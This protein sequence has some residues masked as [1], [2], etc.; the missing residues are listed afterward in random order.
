M[1]ITAVPTNKP[2]PDIFKS[3]NILI[4]SYSKMIVI[5]SEGRPSNENSFC[6]YILNPGDTK[7]SQFHLCHHLGISFSWSLYPHVLHLEND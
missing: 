4:E 6:G 3:G 7:H 2:N 1:R 5:V